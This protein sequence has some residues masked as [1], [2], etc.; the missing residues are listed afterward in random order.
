MEGSKIAS[1]W[2]DRN[3]LPLERGECMDFDD[4]P[5][6]FKRLLVASLPEDME[7]ISVSVSKDDRLYVAG[8]RHDTKEPTDGQENAD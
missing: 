8:L 1:M 6:T 4:M 5:L 3:P 2:L 7:P